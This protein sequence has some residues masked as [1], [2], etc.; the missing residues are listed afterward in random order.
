MKIVINRCSLNMSN[1]ELQRNSNLKQ[2]K[3]NLSPVFVGWL[4]NPS[5]RFSRA[6]AGSKRWPRRDK[7]SC[8]SSSRCCCRCCCFR[9]RGRKRLWRLLTRTRCTRS[10]TRSGTCSRSTCRSS[11]RSRRSTVSRGNGGG[12][13][14]RRFGGHGFYR[15]LF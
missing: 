5:Y 1:E 12:G 11:T 2:E 15:G 10:G 13:S 3:G 6:R 4:S 14:S 7:S 8:F 9:L